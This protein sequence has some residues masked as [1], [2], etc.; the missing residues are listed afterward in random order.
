VIKINVCWLVFHFSTK[1]VFRKVVYVYSL[2]FYQVWC[3]L[4]IDRRTGLASSLV[5]A[6]SWHCE[7]FPEH[8]KGKGYQQVNKSASVQ[9]IVL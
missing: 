2:S 9:S 8:I 1:P 4:F 5:A 6:T 7:L 3:S